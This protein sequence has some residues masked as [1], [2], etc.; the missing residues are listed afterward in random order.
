MTTYTNPTGTFDATSG[1]DAIIFNV[2]PTAIASV[3]ALTGNDSLLIQFDYPFGLTYD[4]SDAFNVGTL[5]AGVSL[6][7]FAPWS[8]GAQDV[9][10]V[11]IHGT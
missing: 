7:P 9:E 6:S 3:D 5:S 10:N 11:E 1:D 2:A 8:V 4:I